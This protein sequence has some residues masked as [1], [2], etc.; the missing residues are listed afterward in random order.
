MTLRTKQ[1]MVLNTGASNIGRR[2]WRRIP[3][4]HHCGRNVLQRWPSRRRENGL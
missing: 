3:L 4:L 1:G 2:R